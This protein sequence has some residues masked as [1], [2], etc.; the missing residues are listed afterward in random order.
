MS[1][2]V[3]GDYAY[4][5]SRF[6]GGLLWIVDISDPATPV[7]VSA[8]E[9]PPPGPEDIVV[10]DNY[11]YINAGDGLK[12]LDVSDPAAPVETGIFVDEVSLIWG[13]LAVTG[14]YAYLGARHPY[15]LQVIDI[16]DP[17]APVEVGRYTPPGDGRAVAVAGFFAYVLDE[18]R[19]VL[20][21]VDVSNPANP[22]K[23]AFY[24]LP[25]PTGFGAVAAANSYIYADAGA[26][27]LY[28][29]RHS[30]PV[31]AAPDSAP[32]RNHIL[33]FPPEAWQTH[34]S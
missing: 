11:A 10:V 3:A 6:G 32:T 30:Y 27:G 17:T 14:D 26:A 20:K 21:M 25:N 2:A 16:S 5:V 22:T 31:S 9:L 18:Y 34:W 19:S 33:P 4:A 29:L 28:I 13:D 7:E 15:D 12:I 24:D 8:T 23:A 1:V